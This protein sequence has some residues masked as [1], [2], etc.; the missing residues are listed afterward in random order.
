MTASLTMFCQQLMAGLHIQKFELENFIL[1]IKLFFSPCDNKL[2][3]YSV[4]DI[5]SFTPNT[6]GRNWKE[7]W[8]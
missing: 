8:I 3:M 6:L 1:E 5:K 7:S 4:G 2:W